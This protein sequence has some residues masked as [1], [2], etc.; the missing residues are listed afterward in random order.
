MLED[1]SVKFKR[2]RFS[3]SQV[4]G[5]IAQYQTSGL[6]QKDF[7]ASI[8]IGC[9][10]FTGWLRRHRRN[11][12]PG[13]SAFVAVDVAKAAVGPA[14]QVECPNGLRLSVPVGFDLKE[15]GHL[16]QLL[17]ACSP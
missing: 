3:K 14:Y 9:S 7:A 13:G 8:A 4:A 16:L 12:A 10:T 5:F 1:V 17:R 6:T 2:R 15:V 11:P